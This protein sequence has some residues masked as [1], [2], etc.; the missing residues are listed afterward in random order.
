M[1]KIN[2]DIARLDRF[3]RRVGLDL[4]ERGVNVRVIDLGTRL[5]KYKPGG[6]GVVKV[7]ASILSEGG[8]TLDAVQHKTTQQME[9][10]FLRLVTKE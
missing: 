8:A 9:A 5:L 3:A 10:L 6:K 2:E 4:T 1:S 7:E